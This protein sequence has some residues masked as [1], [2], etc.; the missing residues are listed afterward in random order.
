MTSNFLRQGQV[1]TTF[2]PGAM[3][4]LPRYSVII[5]GLSTWKGPKAEIVEPRL[6]QKLQQTLGLPHLQLFAPPIHDDDPRGKF[7]CI[8]ARVFPTWFIV[9]KAKPSGPARQWRRRRLVRWQ[10]LDRGVFRD[11]DEGKQPVVP[12]RFV[13]G[14]PHGHIDDLDWRAYVHGRGAECSRPMWLEERGTSGDIGETYA[15]CDCG[16]ERSLYEALGIDTAALGWCPGKRPWL[17]AFAREDCKQPQRLLVRT[18]SNAY[19]PQLMSVISLPEQDDGIAQRI[20]AIWNILQAVQSADMLKT[21]RAIPDVAAALDGVGDDEVMKEIERRRKGYGEGEQSPVKPAE[22]EILNSGH[23]RIG[24]DDPNS[25][26]FAETLE[27]GPWDAA[28]DARWA[29]IDR[30]VLVHRLREVLALLGFTRF[31]AVN[32]NTDGELDLDIMPAALDVEPTWLPAVEHRGEGV[33]VSFKAEAVAAWMNRDAVKNRGTE[34][35][36]GF[37]RWCKERRDAKR[38][39]PGVPFIML[40]SLSHLLLTA[41]AL[42]CGYPASSL[43]ER[44]YAGQGQYGILIYTGS[45]DAE[46]TLGGLVEAGRNLANHLGRALDLARLCSND[47]VCSE[48]SPANEHEGRPLQGAACHGCLL[49]AETC[50]EQRNDLLDRALLVPTVSLAEAAFFRPTSFAQG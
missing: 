32:P 19:F 29:A 1:V 16:Q 12:V 26:F 20:G 25:S 7:A 37:D 17:G 5:T 42:E 44:V 27:R 34:L 48:H 14:C 39:F 13:C 49:I 6:V 3:V 24:R 8:G 30:V 33:F 4:D 40:H 38:V 9:Q 10:D 31:E 43:R 18:A 46:G 47:P 28:G 35:M 11:P 41:I 50:C 36:R 2:G 23:P 45:S 22:F 21:F 15:G